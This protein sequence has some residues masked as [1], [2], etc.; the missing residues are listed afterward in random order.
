MRLPFLALLLLAAAGQA[1]AVEALDGEAIRKAFEGNTVSGRYFGGTG[2][3]TEYH[4]PDGRA[5]GH[6]GHQRNTDACWAI[7]GDS[8]CYYYGKDTT[9][10]QHCFTVSLVNRLYVLTVRGRDRIN[11]LA[12]IEPGNPRNHGDDG[13][14]WVCNGLVSSLRGRLAAR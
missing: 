2:F 7:L 4:Q 6:N 13:K 14:P 5:L 1:R 3:F 11:A 12:T 10:T 9:R 8:I